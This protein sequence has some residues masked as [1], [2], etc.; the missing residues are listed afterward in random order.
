M[1]SLSTNGGLSFSSPIQVSDPSTV[2][3]GSEPAVGPHG[4]IYVA[5]FQFA[6]PKGSG[7]VVAKSTNGGISFGAPVFAASA[8]PIGFNSGNMLGNFRVNSFPRIDVDQSNGNVYV[9]YASRPGHG[10]SGDV[11]FV[12]ST[13]GGATWSSPLRLNTR[14]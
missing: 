13:N 9:T 1:F 4:E 11:F 3:Q 10:D 6:G 8:A 2:N 14:R 12:R 7:I 5:W